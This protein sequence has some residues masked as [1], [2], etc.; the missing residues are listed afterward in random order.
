[1]GGWGEKKEPKKKKKTYLALG[2]PVDERKAH[3]T[4]SDRQHTV[5]N[6]R[7]V[8]A[9]LGPLYAEAEAVDTNLAANPVQ[10]R[11]LFRKLLEFLLRMS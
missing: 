8:G 9:S 3:Q 4:L 6:S 10:L 7:L 11:Q 5:A 1:M 2:E